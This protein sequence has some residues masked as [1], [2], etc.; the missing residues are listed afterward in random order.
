VQD[1]EG[2]LHPIVNDCV[3]G[4]G[5]CLRGADD[6]AQRESLLRALFD[7]YRWD[8]EFGGHDIGYEAPEIMLEQGTWAERELVARWVREA[9]PADDSWSRRWRR[10]VFGRL[11]LGLAGDAVDDETYLRICRETGRRRDLVEKLLALRRV[12]EAEA[13]A[14]LADDSEL[15][16][17]ADLLRERGHIERAE[18]LVREHQPAPQWQDRYDE[19]RRERARERGDVTAALALSEELF[20]RHPS[21]PRY[22]ALQALAETHRSWDALRPEVLRRLERERQYVLLTESHLRAGEI[23]VAIE[24]VRQ[25][26]VAGSFPYAYGSEP[27]SMRVALAAEPEFPREAI[28]LYTSTAERLIQA[29]G[30]DNYAAAARYLARVRDLYRRLGEGAAWDALIGSIREHNRRLRAL[31][32]EL[33][34]AGL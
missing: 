22:E 14:R 17:L 12:D 34:R 27:L 18:H 6:P 3:S 4:L 1:E 7:I 29:Q 33:D 9:M 10:Q 11:L 25:A 19:W 32:E 5:A 24:A 21:L 8:V 13:E 30:R 23:A 31:K 16:T 28:A 20:W 26:G 15:L 2:A